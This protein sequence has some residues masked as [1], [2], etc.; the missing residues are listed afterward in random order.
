MCRSWVRH[1]DP[2]TGRLQ[3]AGCSACLGATHSAQ[4]PSRTDLLVLPARRS[5][6]RC[7][8]GG[9]VGLWVSG[10]TANASDSR[11]WPAVAPAERHP[12]I[13]DG[14]FSAAESLFVK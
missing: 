5:V 11:R 6:E 14:A 3:Q 7:V 13:L 10:L 4:R 8:H 9:V 2:T 1:G 12:G